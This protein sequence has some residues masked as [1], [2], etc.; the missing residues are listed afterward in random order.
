M[1]N[2]KIIWI[3]MFLVIGIF[4]I[5]GASAL[6]ST[7][8]CQK[9]NDGFYCQDTAQ[10]NCA[11]GTTWAPTA[12]ASTSFCKPGVCYNSQQGTCLDSTPKIVCDNSNGIWSDGNPPQCALGC[13]ILGD[14]A[15]FVTLVR[16]KYLASN[17]GLNTN[18]DTSIKTETACVLAVQSQD[19]GACIYDFE[20]QKTCKFTTRLNC[21]S[22][23]SNGTTATGQFFKGKLCTAEEL[24]DTCTPTTKTECIPGKDEVYF[25]D[26]CGNR[27]N[28]YDS[29]KLPTANNMQGSWREY[30]TDVKAKADSCGADSST[31]NINSASCGNCNY[32]LGSY[33]RSNTKGNSPEN[34][35]SDLNCYDLQG[36]IAKKL[37]G[38]SWCVYNDAGTTGVGDNTVGSR[39]YKHIC[40][41]GQEILEQCADFRNEECIQDSINSS[42]GSFTQAA[43]RVNRWQDCT[44]QNDSADCLNTDQRDCLWHPGL[45]GGNGSTY[46][47][48]LP[49]N[50]PGLNF[51]SGSVA[52]SVCAQASTTCTVGYEKGLF[53]SGYGKCKQNCDCETQSW[54][55]DRI[56]VCNALGDCG[57]K[58]NW[59]GAAGTTTGY[60]RTIS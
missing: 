51:W 5:F 56:M 45:S 43:C 28:I 46:N 48:C 4:M 2:K 44:A 23:T 14:Q 57:S 40:E 54:L 11:D 52:Q 35:C 49:K 42:A 38:E 20:F 58:T 39:F 55:N 6:N 9:T 16:C 1:I 19:E 34:I 47:A 32:G 37:H 50:T 13:C 10:S 59:V 36:G 3:G 27:A 22:M 18:Y 8:C 30:W 53:D 41:N 17:F 21:N 7:V 12:C 24:N 26:S 29:S 60:T 33:C 25:M 15:A 31:G